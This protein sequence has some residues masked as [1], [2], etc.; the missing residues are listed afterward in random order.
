MGIAADLEEHEQRMKSRL[1]A[2]QQSGDPPEAWRRMEYHIAE[3]R[4]IRRQ[5]GWRIDALEK[6]LAELRAAEEVRR[7]AYEAPRS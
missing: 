1:A 4:E 6:E 7:A 5:F 2:A 3:I